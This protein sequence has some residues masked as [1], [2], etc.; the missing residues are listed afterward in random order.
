M[1]N[2]G[3]NVWG[4]LMKPF[5]LLYFF[6]QEPPG[7]SKECSNSGDDSSG[8][9]SSSSCGHG[10]TS[11]DGGAQ[12]CSRGAFDEG[13]PNSQSQGPSRGRR[14]QATAAGRHS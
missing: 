12:Q 9:R 3:F 11:G 1:K 14:I 7:H 13:E 10:V 8:D 5:C 2:V 4:T 6:D